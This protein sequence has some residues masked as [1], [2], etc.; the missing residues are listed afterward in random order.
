MPCSVRPRQ[1]GI[2][3]HERYHES[4]NN[5]TPADVYFGRGRQVLDRREQSKLNTLATLCEVHYDKQMKLQ[6]LI[7]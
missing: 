2:L 3:S 7:S 4:L 1:S 6:T 5:L